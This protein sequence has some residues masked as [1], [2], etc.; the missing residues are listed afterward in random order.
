VKEDEMVRACNT[1]G[2]KKNL[3]RILVGKT[4]GKRPL[5]GSRH[6]WVGNIKME[7]KKD[8]R[9][10]WYGLDTSGSV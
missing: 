2:Q 8:S 4:E 6:S 9:M 3:Y 5:G 7:L 1:N 10:G